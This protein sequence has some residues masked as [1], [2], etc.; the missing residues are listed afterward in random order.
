MTSSAPESAAPAGGR[1]A[2]AA[3]AVIGLRERKK[4]RTR[5]TIRSEAIRLFSE[6]GF[7]AT[8]VEQIAEAADISPSTFFRYFATKEAVIVTDEYDPLMFQEFRDQPLELAPVRAFRNALR[9]VF[10]QMDEAALEQEQA[11]QKLLQSV[12]E[13]RSA[14]LEEF[15]VSIGL[16][17]EMIGERVGKPAD[18]LGVRT[19]AGA[20]IGVVLSVTVAYWSSPSTEA[21]LEISHLVDEALELLELGL[22]L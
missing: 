11:R 20:I 16:L 17:A 10:G 3:P 12:P 7:A 15:G 9:I 21:L 6:R 2:G 13:L 1:P 22:P 14:M 4:A 18:D 19:L 8:T 5:A